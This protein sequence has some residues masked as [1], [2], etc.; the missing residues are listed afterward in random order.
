MKRKYLRMV[1]GAVTLCTTLGVF[2]NVSS[3]VAADGEIMYTRVTKQVYAVTTTEA[4]GRVESNIAVDYYTNPN[5]GPVLGILH[6]TNGADGKNE[7]IIEQIDGAYTYVFKDMNQNGTLDPYEDWRLSVDERAE[8]LA[9]SL[10]ATDEGVQK[11]A[12]L[13][14]FS[15][16]E[17]DSSAGLTEAQMEYL[18]TSYVRNITD[19]AGNNVKDAVGW[20][21]AMQAYVEASGFN[22]PVD[23]S[24]DPRS[25]AGSGDLYSPAATESGI[26]AW[27]SNI[28]LAATFDTQHMYNFA[29]ASS[30]E[31]RAMGIVTALGPQIDLATEPR[32]LR[33]GGT[34]GENTALTTDMTQAYVDGSQSTYDSAGVDIGWGSDSI[35]AMI[36]HFPG[37]GAGE[38]GRES[39]MDAGKYA[40]YPG[41][42]FAEHLIPFVEGGMQLQGKTESATAVMTSYSIGINADGSVYGGNENRM[43][44]AY[45]KAK[46]A[47]LREQLNYDGVVCTDWGVTTSIF[48]FGMAWGAEGMSVTERH[49]AVLDAGSDMFGGNNDAAPVM[50]AFEL[51]KER[52]SEAYARQR[53]AVSAKRL[54]KLTMEP[55]LFENPYLE[56]ETAQAVVGSADKR[57]AG[58]A[59]QLDSIVMLKNA[60]K[61][62][63]AAANTEKDPSEMT[64]YIPI[65]YTKEQ[66][67]VWSLEPAQ[68]SE[69]MNLD[70]ARAIYG[71]VITDELQPDGTYKVPD[72]SNVDKVIIGMRS[73]M[74]GGTFS[75]VGQIVN[76]DGTKTY[77]PLSLQ[78]LPYTAD[79]DNVRKISIAGDILADNTQENRS[80]YGE[81]SR[82]LNEYDL[83]MTLQVVEA[84]E[85]LGKDI[86]IVVAMNASGPAIVSEFEDKVD[87]IIVGFSVSDQALFDVI[88]GNHEPRGLLPIQ[89]P[90]D[91]DTVEANL[92]DVGQDVIAY[93][94]TQGNTYDFAYGLNWSGLIDDERVATYNPNRP[95]GETKTLKVSANAFTLS[96]DEASQATAA[97]L[98]EKAAVKAEWVNA[99]TRS[100]RTLDPIEIQIHDDHVQAIKAIGKAGGSY[101]ATFTATANGQSKTIDVTITVQAAASS[102]TS[103]GAITNTGDSTDFKAFAMLGGFALL[104]VVV[105][106]NKKRN[107]K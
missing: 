11:I 30:A 92:E 45:N 53:F 3:I 19:A 37:D 91:M 101:T 96:N 102:S 5:E 62:I 80:Y 32:W 77:Y 35:N 42:N 6:N 107:V 99:S 27:P 76:A 103:A 25:T 46:M 63:Q 7:Y 56:V 47:L 57:A 73:P 89:F 65:T 41:S 69:S 31:Y 84:V 15:A 97:M 95:I 8:D 79:G 83:T 34:F 58:Y 81:T 54:V 39:H 100:A 72:L 28:G 4:D 59:A 78:Y 44:S 43:G 33:V 50:E 21:N 94:D 67:T 18:D 16:H 24:S 29:K 36:K 2:S 23:F 51:F 38:G 64:V 26:S 82:L 55:G 1:K 74:N 93:K 48:G 13:M 20:S 61:S 70:T 87:A 75:N 9:M 88:N 98:I 17:R 85:A 40:V 66:K 104:F 86:P 14:L 52:Y 90:Q 68:Y 105:F 10:A 22:V 71:T 49:Y 106:A 12:G 60:N